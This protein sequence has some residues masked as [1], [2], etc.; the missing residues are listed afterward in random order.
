MGWVVVRR[1]ADACVAM[2]WRSARPV[3]LWLGRSKCGVGSVAGTV[4]THEV[5][6][7]GLQA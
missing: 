7:A 6:T 3:G 1:G 4:L 5:E 2:R